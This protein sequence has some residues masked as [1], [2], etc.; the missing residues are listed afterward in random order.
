MAQELYRPGEHTPVERRSMQ[1]PSTEIEIIEN[2]IS[3][4]R[5]KVNLFDRMVAHR[6]AGKNAAAVIVA[7]QKDVADAH[8]EIVQHHA[9]MIARS[10]K[11]E[12]TERFQAGLMDLTRRVEERVAGET[13][14][15]WQKLAERED[16][17]EDF[18]RSRIESM[19]EK[20][21]K[22]EMADERAQVRIKRYED[23]RDRQQEQDKFLI[24]ELMEAN[25][26]ILRKA[27]MDYQ[28]T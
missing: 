10:R 11:M 25:R 3:S 9:N 15:Y 23:D 13:A 16:Y 21:A 18:F 17:Y 14:H 24:D 5:D 12:I 1:K 27:L 7:M 19:K 28:P 4:V 6:K 20:V 26:R 8:R 2:S 22:G